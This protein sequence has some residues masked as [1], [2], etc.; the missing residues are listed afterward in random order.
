M[1]MKTTILSTLLV[2]SLSLFAQEPPKFL[3][4]FKYQ[5]KTDVT[6]DGETFEYYVITDDEF[7]D[8]KKFAMKYKKTGTEI[9]KNGLLWV[10]REIDGFEVMSARG[11]GF[12]RF[13]I[14][15]E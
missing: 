4:G 8:F 7:N 12:K 6:E 14:V 3:D 15:Q 13:V 10:Y 11:F 1:K 5:V 2:A 9:E